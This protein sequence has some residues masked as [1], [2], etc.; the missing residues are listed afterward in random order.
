[1]S[2][3][4]V[5]V[6]K[7]DAQLDLGGE[8]SLQEVELLGLPTSPSALD[9]TYVWVRNDGS[10]QQ[11]GLYYQVPRLA[12]IGN[13]K[14]NERGNFFFDPGRGGG[15]LDK[16]E[17]PA[18]RFMARYIAASHFG[19]VNAYYH[20]DRAARWSETL[21]GELGARPLPRVGVVV[22]AHDG[23]RYFD[24]VCDGVCGT[25]RWLPF[26]GGHYR[27]SQRPYGPLEHLPIAPDGEIHVGPGW[28]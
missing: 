8:V 2:R 12:T 21:L 9:G 20:V 10:V 4:R 7:P 23:Q 28:C 1:M 18:P 24:D 17:D 11:R 3:G 19:E 22:N 15:R 6:W 27:L 26:Q 5:Y 14:P 16:A 25:R 13:A